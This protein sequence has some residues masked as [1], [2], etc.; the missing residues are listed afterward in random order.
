MAWHYPQSGYAA[1]VRRLPQEGT[2]GFAEVYPEDKY[3]VVERLQAAGHVVGMT[4]DGVN[5]APA[6]R[7]A[8]VGIVNKIKPREPMST[9]AYELPF[10]FPHGAEE[11][12]KRLAACPDIPDVLGPRFVKMYLGMKEKEFSEY[13]RVI[14]PW[15]RKYLLLHV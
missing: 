5:D 3:T 8:E 10:Q 12:L 13:F 6:L 15:E 7:Q 11:S 1:A 4:G 14:S 9:D 2:D